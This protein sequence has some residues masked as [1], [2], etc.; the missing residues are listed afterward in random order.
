LLKLSDLSENY[1][2][3]KIKMILS[4]LFTLLLPDINGQVADTLKDDNFSFHAQTTIINQ[5]KPAFGAKYTG[6]NSLLPESER[7]ISVTATLFLGARLWKGASF[8]FNPEIGAGSGL[9]SSFGVGASTNGETYRVSDPS[10]QFELARLFFRQIFPLSSDPVYSETDI[11]KLGGPIPV[12][13]FSFTIGKLCV[14]DFFDLNKFSHDPRTQFMSWALMSNGAYDFPANTRG[15]TPSVI[16]EYITA[17][18][19]LRYGFSLVPTVRNGMT[20]NWNI[21]E[22][23]SHSL[24]YTHRHVIQGKDGAIRLITFFN[25]AN[26]GSYNESLALNP[27]APELLDTQK[28]GRTKLGFGINIEQDLSKYLGVFLRAS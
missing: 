2:F 27:S 23:G 16:L 8:F 3:M 13:Y 24:E 6:K 10:P 11:N 19:E 18:N 20:M 25:I 7:P 14:S 28:K 26:M 9:S 21:S 4:V 15:Y 5:N 22:A 12:S 1:I 17:R